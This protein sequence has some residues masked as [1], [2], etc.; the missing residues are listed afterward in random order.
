MVSG[1]KARTITCELIR[2]S[3]TSFAGML[4]GRYAT[5]SREEEKFWQARTSP[6][7]VCALTFIILFIYFTYLHNDVTFLCS[8]KCVFLKVL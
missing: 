7:K 3:H 2:V 6:M 4:S 8:R 5:G 1:S